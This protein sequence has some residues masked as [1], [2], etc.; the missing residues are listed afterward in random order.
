MF[1]VI[2]V[3]FNIRN[4]LP[5]SGTFLLGHPVYINSLRSHTVVGVLRQKCHS[6]VVTSV[7]AD[8]PIHEA[9]WPG[10]PQLSRGNAA[11]STRSAT[12]PAKRRYYTPWPSGQSQPSNREVHLHRH[13]SARGRQNASSVNSRQL[14]CFLPQPTPLRAQ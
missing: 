6:P 13:P 8:C 7:T 12:A 9:A 14:P 2:S 3:Y 11:N 5:K 10:R 1:W 4:T